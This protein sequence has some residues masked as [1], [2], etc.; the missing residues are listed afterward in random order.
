MA[1]VLEACAADGVAVVP[2][3]GGTSVVGGV[4]AV[5]G[6]HRAVI[7]LDLSRMRDCEV[8]RVSLTARLGPGLRGPRPRPRSPRRA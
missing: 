7:A 2:F 6:S 3:G 4:D 5:R 8:D 1:A